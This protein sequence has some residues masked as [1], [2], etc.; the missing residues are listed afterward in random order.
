MGQLGIA[1]R[2]F[3]ECVFRETC[4][5]LV[6]SL[7]IQ[8]AHLSLTVLHAVEAVGCYSHR[9]G[10]HAMLGDGSIFIDGHSLA[11]RQA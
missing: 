7:I 6:D 11:V 3:R 10:R 9:V 1:R 2:I 8:V 5:E 4:R